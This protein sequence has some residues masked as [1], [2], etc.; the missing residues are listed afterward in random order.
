MGFLFTNYAT[1][2]IVL[3]CV[4]AFYAAKAFT[5]LQVIEEAAEIC[6]R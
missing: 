2:K 3:T 1:L 5:M 4:P 6:D